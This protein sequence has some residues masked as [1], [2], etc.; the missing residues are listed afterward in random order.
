MPLPDNRTPL[1]KLALRKLGW[2]RKKVIKSASQ[3]DSL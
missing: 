3:L 1:G 2:F